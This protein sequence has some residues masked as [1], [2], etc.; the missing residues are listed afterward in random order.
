MIKT[1]LDEKRKNVFDSIENIKVVL[2]LDEHY[3][4]ILEEELK[5]ERNL[6]AEL[7]ARFVKCNT[8]T[9]EMKEHCIMF[10]ENLC[11]GERCEELVDLMALVEK[12]NIND[13]MT[14]L[15]Q[16]IEEMKQD[17]RKEQS[18]WNTC[19]MQYE[20]LQKLLNKWETK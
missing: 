14:K 9:K 16:K 3:I 7:K 10:S 8:C 5:K 1:E 4:D 6:N 12:R 2:G 13:E 15:E 11:E 18:Y 19:D 17:V 20:L